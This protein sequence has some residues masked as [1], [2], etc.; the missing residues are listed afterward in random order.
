MAE[1]GL[2]ST[3]NLRVKQFND[4]V[5]VEMNKKQVLKPYMGTDAAA[6]I[7]VKDNLTKK[8]GDEDVFALKVALMR[9]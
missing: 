8:A 2:S 1:S 7:Q 5:F 4:E 6:V 9:N 3:S